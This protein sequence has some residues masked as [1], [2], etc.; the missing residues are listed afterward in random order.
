ML[1]FKDVCAW[2]E[3]ELGCTQDIVHTIDTA[4]QQAIRQ[5]SRHVPFA[6][7]GKVEQ[8]VEKMLRQG[9][10]QPSTVHGPAQLSW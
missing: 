10:I 1:E 3:S 9:V 2:D 7:R 6:L 4:D 8:M 5:P